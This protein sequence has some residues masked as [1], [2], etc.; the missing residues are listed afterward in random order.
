[1]PFFDYT[2]RQLPLEGLMEKDAATSRD[3]GGMESASRRAEVEDEN[4]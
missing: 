3:F 4:T 1:M 2:I